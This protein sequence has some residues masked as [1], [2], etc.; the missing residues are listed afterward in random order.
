MREKAEHTEAV[1]DTDQHD[2]LLCKAASIE[3][4]GP[5]RSR[6]EPSSVDPDHDGPSVCS[7]GRTSPNVQKKAIL[8]TV[9]FT[10]RRLRAR[11][12]DRWC[13]KW[14]TSERSNA[15]VNGAHDRATAYTGL[16]DSRANRR[17]QR[18]P[19]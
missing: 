16:L 5:R 6:V 19:Q 13:G 9:I 2:S 14:D 11:R 1:R 12:P 18:N 10:A 3:R 7:V 8:S 17:W 15:I 4:W